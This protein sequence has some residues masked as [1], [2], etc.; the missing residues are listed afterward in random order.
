M[1]IYNIQKAVADKFG[2]QNIKYRV[3]NA[4]SPQQSSKLTVPANV[5]MQDAKSQLYKP[6]ISILVNENEAANVGQYEMFSGDMPL[7]ML[8]T[9]VFSQLLFSDVLDDRFPNQEKILKHIYPVDACL[10]TVNQAKNIV[11]TQIQG[12]NGTI[13]EFIN[14]GDFTI[15]IK[16]LICSTKQNLYPFNEVENLKN[17]LI[18]NKELNIEVPFLADMFD[19]HTIVIESYSFPQGEGEIAMQPFTIQAISDVPAYAF[20]L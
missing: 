10:F 7:S 17:F 3:Y 18:Q 19:I 13:K 16:G 8:G 14:Q 11:K 1:G 9:P 2:Y 5:L 4:Q 15:E 6:V 12:Q 20:F